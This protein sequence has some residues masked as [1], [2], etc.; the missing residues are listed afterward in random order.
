MFFTKSKLKIK[1]SLSG[2]TENKRNGGEENHTTFSMQLRQLI[3]KTTH[4]EVK[5]IFEKKGIKMPKMFYFDLKKFK[6]IV[7]WN[8]PQSTLENEPRDKKNQTENPS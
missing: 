5:Q 2:H 3:L 7:I 1:K 6:I 8:Q 4:V